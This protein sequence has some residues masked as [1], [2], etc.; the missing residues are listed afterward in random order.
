MAQEQLDELFAQTLTG[1]CDDESAWEA[2]RTLRRMGTREVFEQAAEWCGSESP[3]K[4]ARG[5]DVLAQLGR[6]VDHPSNNF[7][8]ESFSIISAL[9]QREKDPWPLSSAV[10]ALGGIGNALAVPLVI[11]HRLHPDADVRFAVACV[12]GTFATDPRSVDELLGLM[13]DADEDVR[14]WATFGLGVLGDLDSPEIRDALW[15][16]VS[17]P[18]RDVREESLVGLSKRKDQRAVPA[19]ID[20]LN[21]P[22][23]SSRV[24]E[25]ADAFLVDKERAADRSPGDYVAALKKHLPL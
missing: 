6:T 9:P 11:E 13:R 8:E 21:Q 4:R 25:A 16:R 12:L 22:E 17:D 23:I 24:I 19:L 14:D 20:E 10:H 18:N 1:D 7:S 2:V 15:E 3:L 5:A